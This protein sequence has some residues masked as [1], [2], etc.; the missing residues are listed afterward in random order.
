MADQNQDPNL[1]QRAGD[2]AM[3][4]AVDTTAD[5][6]INQGLEAVEG[7]VAIPG[8]PMV[9]KMINTEV[10]QLVNNEIN[11]ELNKG[12]GGILGDAEGLFGHR[13]G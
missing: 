8:G 9:D 2:F 5:N 4:A 12:A 3:D 1:I 7:R 10:D 11:N 6:F 13:N